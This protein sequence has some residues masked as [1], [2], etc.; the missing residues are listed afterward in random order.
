M[1]FYLDSSVLVKRYVAEVGSIR[2]SEIIDSQDEIYI[3][4]IAQVEVIA[5]LTRRGKLSRA[6]A[7]MMRLAR[8]EFRKDYASG[9]FRAA[10]LTRQLLSEAAKLAE[11]RELRGYDAVQL[12]TALKLQHTQPDSQF[13]LVCADAELIRAATLEGLTVE[14][15][16]V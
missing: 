2:V 5:A 15:V 13:V 16:A 1:S 8:D 4:D 10:V 7:E 6:A 9:T 14:S 3:S 12:A 11:R